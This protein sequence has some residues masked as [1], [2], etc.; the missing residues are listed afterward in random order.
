VRLVF[1]GK[2]VEVLTGTEKVLRWNTD[3][4]RP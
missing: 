4:I 3:L 1:L 2:L